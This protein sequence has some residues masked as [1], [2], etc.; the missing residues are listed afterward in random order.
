MCHR[1]LRELW[2]G[3]Q[4]VVMGNKINPK[5]VM[6]EDLVQNWLRMSQR[7]RREILEKVIRK[8]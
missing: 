5:I 3:D 8:S 4:K 7:F 1:P 6:D 2:K